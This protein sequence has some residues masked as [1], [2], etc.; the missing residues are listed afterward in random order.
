MPFTSR[1]KLGYNE[2]H[3][4]ANIC[5]LLLWT[6]VLKVVN[7]DQNVDIF[8]KNWFLKIEFKYREWVIIFEAFL[9]KKRDYGTII[10][11]FIY[12]PLSRNEFE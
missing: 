8:A 7:L 3:G 6:S 9:L 12:Q 11:N 5:S 2:I 1:V 10:V 4:T